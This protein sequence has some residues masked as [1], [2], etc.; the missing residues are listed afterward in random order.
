[1][2]PEFLRTVGIELVPEPVTSPVRIVVA[3]V[4]LCYN[5]GL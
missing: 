5:I 3:I 1:M 4:Y 2:A